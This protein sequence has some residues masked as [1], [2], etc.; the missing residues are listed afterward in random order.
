MSAKKDK[1][2]FAFCDVAP[3]FA[4]G[5]L[6]VFTH[7][8]RIDPVIGVVRLLIWDGHAWSYEVAWWQDGEPCLGRF[9]GIELK[10]GE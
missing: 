5:N 2:G 6:V 10:A 7:S 4:V 3:Q 1:S 8:G 9:S